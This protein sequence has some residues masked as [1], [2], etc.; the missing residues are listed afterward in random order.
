M[1]KKLE[2][3]RNFRHVS[4]QD[5]G[6]DFND[7]PHSPLADPVSAEKSLSP[8]GADH[9]SS[10]A[11]PHPLPVPESLL[12]RRRESSGSVLTQGHL[13]SSEEGPGHVLGR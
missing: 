3:K 6:L 5:L 11:V 4:E 1:Q 12:T 2:R 7:R 13:G 10:V 9:W 8:G